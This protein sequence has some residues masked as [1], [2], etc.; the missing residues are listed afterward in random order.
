MKVIKTGLLISFLSVTGILYAQN[1]LDALNYS[2]SRPFGTGLALATSGALG[3]VGADMGSYAINPAGLGFY[4]KNEFNISMGLLNPN[5]KSEYLGYFMSDNLFGLTLPNVS[6]VYT[7]L[8]HEKGKEKDDELVSYNFAFQVNRYNNFYNKT[9]YQGKN[10]QSSFMDMIWERAQGIKS[11]NE[12]GSLAW[13]AYQTYLLDPNDSIPG[14]WGIRMADKRSSGQTGIIETRGGMYDWNFGGSFNYGNVLYGGIS[15]HYSKL[16][17]TEVNTFREDNN[18]FD[19]GFKNLTFVQNIKSDGSG[20]GIKAGFIFRPVESFR[21]GFSFQSPEKISITD[22]YYYEM[23]STFDP[24]FSGAPPTLINVQRDPEINT[25]TIA[26]E[27]DDK[28][29]FSYYVRTPSRMNYSASYVTGNFGFISLDVERV[30]YASISMGS[31]FDNYLNENTF[32]KSDFRSTYNI[33]FGA[34][35]LAGKD[36]RLRA[37][38]AHYESPY[39]PEISELKNDY[40]EWSF[41]AGFGIIK[42]TYGFDL[43][44]MQ[45]RYRDQY[46]PYMSAEPYPSSNVVRKIGN[47]AMTASLI[48][49]IDPD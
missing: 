34:E 14:K 13:V 12:L 35:V 25:S 10:Y 15:L 42:K 31:E 46:V 18:Y 4:R 6:Y 19:E 22:K 1:E 3:S 40:S 45:S 29:P 20:Y 23:T 17:K 28:Y 49:Y 39:R 43:G 9:F 11:V 33:R 2:K 47:F 27:D 16:K 44:F 7:K 30:N 41:S 24:S 26:N 38:V 8:L 32:I 5:T 37:G 21:L 36:I 48:F